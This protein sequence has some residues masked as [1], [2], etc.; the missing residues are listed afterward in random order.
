MHSV[1]AYV[2]LV[3][4][5]P[6]PKV[7]DLLQRILQDYPNEAFGAVKRLYKHDRDY[8][9][10]LLR[11]TFF[12]SPNYHVLTAMLRH[13]IRLVKPA[14]YFISLAE[15]NARLSSSEFTDSAQVTW[16]QKLDDGWQQVLAYTPPQQV[17][18]IMANYLPGAKGRVA[19]N[20]VL[21]LKEYLKLGVDANFTLNA[22][23]EPLLIELLNARFDKVS[24]VCTDVL[25]LLL[26]RMANPAIANTA[27]LQHIETSAYRMM[28][29]AALKVA[30]EVP[31]LQQVQIDYFQR[32]F[33]EVGKGEEYM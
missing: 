9:R 8:A 10:Q 1:N 26:P 19:R 4:Q 6:Y 31:E 28:D 12:N 21:Q 25:R 13:M 17:N 30:A 23:L 2:H 7:K 32:R 22:E 18:E 24:T 3:N 16:P 5:F 15:I 11:N 20:L 29:A 27:L 33:A 14:E